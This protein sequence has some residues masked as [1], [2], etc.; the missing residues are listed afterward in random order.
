MFAQGI[1][2][3]LA[4]LVGGRRKNRKAAKARAGRLVRIEPLESR[5]L[6]SVVSSPSPLTDGSLV[7]TCGDL[8]YV[9]GSNA[10][11]IVAADTALS[12]TNNGYNLVSV[13]AVATLDN[14]SN[15][16]GTA[17]YAVSTLP[18]NGPLYRIAVQINGTSI[19]TT[20]RHTGQMAITENYAGGNP[21]YLNLNANGYKDVLNWNTSPFSGLPA[22]FTFTGMDY[23]VAD[24]AGMSLVQ[25]DGSMGY[26][27]SNGNG[28]YTS[29]AGPYAFDT[30]TY[31]NSTYVLDGTDGTAE[32][33]NSNGT[34]S[35]IED[36]DG[37][38]TK[39]N[40]P[41]GVLTT[42][43]DPANHT[44]TFGYPSGQVT[45][46]DFAGRTTTYVATTGQLTI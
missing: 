32:T 41:G 25:S 46:T 43:V 13:T 15:Y 27:S 28:S 26:F 2:G 31:I 11:P 18:T 10:K 40:Y 7:L 36:A 35:K 9:S 37:N 42:I 45:I 8:T 30:L 24:L 44:T 21:P 29:E 38:V 3:G 16:Q 17:T 39:Y 22:H 1:F 12:R 33:F 19:P 5:M 14:N 6:L 4:G 23:L 34:L 20:G